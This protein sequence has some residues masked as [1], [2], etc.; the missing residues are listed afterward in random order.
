MA[1]TLAAKQPDLRLTALRRFAI[2][3]T[4]FNVIGHSYLGFEQ[5]LAQPLASL[6]TAYSLELLLEWVHARANGLKPRFL[7]GPVAFVNFMLSAH[8]SGLAV[9]MLLYANDRLLPICFAAAVAIGSK[10]LF[11]APL[12][13]GGSRHYFNPSNLGITATLLAFPWVGIAAPY[14]FSE[15]LYTRGD[16]VM[17]IIIIISGSFLNT[18]LTKRM[19]LIFTW[20]A[21]FAGQALLRAWIFDRPWQAGLM[22]M[23]GVAFILFTFYMVTDPA[24]TPSSTRGQIWFGISVAA[25]YFLLISNHIVFDLFFALTITCIG[26]GVAL[27]VAAWQAERAS[28]RV[29]VGTEDVGRVRA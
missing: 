27:Y 21:A 3:I 2:A 17:P 12:P 11:R 28:Q 4:L 24:T 18:K 6:A 29:A 26:R 5:S 20:L 15:N 10:Y 14:M 16:W 13:G 7:G 23:T 22:P 19:P 1:E 9:A 8:I 25:T